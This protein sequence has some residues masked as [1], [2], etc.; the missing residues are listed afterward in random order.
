MPDP[1]KKWYRYRPWIGAPIGL[2]SFIPLLTLHIAGVLSGGA[3]ALI[4][5]LCFSAMLLWTMADE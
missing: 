5:A 3:A 2:G 1:N 4:F